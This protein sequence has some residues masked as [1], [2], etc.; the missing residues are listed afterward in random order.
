MATSSILALSRMVRPSLPRL[1]LR[2]QQGRRTSSQQFVDGER[3]WKD[4]PWRD[5]PAEEF[6]S[7]R[8][9]VSDL[10]Q[11]TVDLVVFQ[12]ADLFSSA[13]L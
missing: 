13:T 8:W 1:M 7:Y 3:Y 4:T 9:Q 12:N 2:A 6:N 11:I 10:R 5:T